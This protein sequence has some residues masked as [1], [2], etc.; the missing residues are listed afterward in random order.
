LHTIHDFYSHSNWVEMGNNEINSK[1]GTKDFETDYQF[2]TADDENTCLDNCTKVTVECGFFYNLLSSALS[3]FGFKSNLIGCPLVYFNCDGNLVAQDKLISG[4]YEGQKLPDGTEVLKPKNKNKCSHGG[5]L[6]KTSLTA[7]SGGIN[8]D[9]GFYAISP[10]ASLHLKAA[11][12]A[13]NHTE[14]FFNEIRKQIGDKRF[15]DFLKLEI[16]GDKCVGNR[17]FVHK[18]NIFL[19]SLIVCLTKINSTF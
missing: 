19:I 17:N 5:I 16:D 4:Y 13:V 2:S 8:K 11:H 6:D 10:H 7:S 15:S 9:S 1:I 18:F 3:F 12:L 14:F